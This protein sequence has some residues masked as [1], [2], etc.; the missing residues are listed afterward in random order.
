M[1]TIG[2]IDFSSCW[3]PV[4][5]SEDVV[6]SVTE[7]IFAV[8]ETSWLSTVELSVTVLSADAVCSLETFAVVLDIFA[9]TALEDVVVDAAGAF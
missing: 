1:I 9:T 8:E 5:I 7:L 3:F 4:V 6:V 2:T